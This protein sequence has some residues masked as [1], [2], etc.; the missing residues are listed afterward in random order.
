MIRIRLEAKMLERLPVREK[1]RKKKVR[2]DL[3]FTP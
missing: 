2:V 3:I 1:A